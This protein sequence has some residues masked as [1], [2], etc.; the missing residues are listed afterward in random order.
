MGPSRW[1]SRWICCV[2]LAAGVGAGPAWAQETRSAAPAVPPT[3]D[4]K[5]TKPGAIGGKRVALVIGNA[6]YQRLTSLPN[7]GHDAEDLCA[8]VRALG[9]AATCQTDVPDRAEFRRLLRQFAA[10]L[11]PGTTAL[12]YYAGHAIQSRGDN[13][14]LPVQLEPG[15]QLELEDDSL[16]LSHVLRVLEDARS[17][18]NIIILDA[19]R[20]DPLAG[21]GRLQIS[22]GLAR[23]DP[24]V[25]SLL[26]YATAPGAE[27]LDGRGRNGLFTKHLLAHLKHPGVPLSELLQQVASDVEDEARQLYGFKQVPYRSFS[28]SGTLCLAECNEAKAS[29]QLAELKRRSEEAME[30]MR[31]LESENARLSA[32]AGEPARIEQ[33]R[34]EAKLRDGEMS[35]L[36]QLLQE[37]RQRITALEKEGSERAQQKTADKNGPA[38]KAVRPVVVPAF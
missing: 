19:C 13:F 25:G 32:G 17:A 29:T 21:Q 15:S 6:T 31:Q 34:R 4:L 8:A 5:W 28:Y 33:L 2:A 24:P 22:R 27:A 7:A 10:E 3:R 37:Y 26:V 20:S 9:F 14:L 35:E 18:P 12:F 23:V 36:R 11:G 30:R 1:S 38:E 16:S